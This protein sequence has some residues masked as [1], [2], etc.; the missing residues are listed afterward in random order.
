MCCEPCLKVFDDITV[1]KMLSLRSLLLEEES[2]IF[3]FMDKIMKWLDRERENSYV[4]H[5]CVATRNEILGTQCVPTQEEAGVHFCL[6]D[7][8]FDPLPNNSIKDK[9]LMYF[10]LM[11]SWLQQSLLLRKKLFCE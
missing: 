4:G 1:E 10:D 8:P 6:T 7:P 11:Q 2:K 9:N 3:S 5:N